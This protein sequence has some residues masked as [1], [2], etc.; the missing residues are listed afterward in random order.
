MLTPALKDIL[1]SEL[2]SAINTPISSWENIP[3]GG[4]SINQTWQIIINKKDKYF[5]KINSAEKYPGLFE[6]EKNGLVT[7]RN[8][9]I[10]II[11]EIILHTIIDKY[12]LLIMEWI[13]PAS[14]WY[15]FL[16]RFWKQLATL[17]SITQEQFGLAEDNYMGALPQSNRFEKHWVDF[18]IHQ[19]LQPQLEIAINKQLIQAVQLTAFESLY[20]NLHSIFPNEPPAL[21]HGD[22]WNGN[23][24]CD[25]MQRP[26]LID[27]A[28]YY[29]HR[30]IDLGM[31]TLFGGFENEF[32]NAYF[33]HS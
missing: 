27:P 24:L 12:Q 31:T 11:P 28:I 19:R 18:F 2:Q 15:I 30:A 3:I 29:G 22:L 26:V 33:Y 5:C 4:G 20:K 16:G 25:E 1:K 6:K 32:Y 9:N 8:K 21:L 17:H 10:F 14:P 23:F 13:E 7:L